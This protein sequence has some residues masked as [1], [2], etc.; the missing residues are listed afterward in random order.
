MRKMIGDK[1]LPIQD[2]ETTLDTCPQSLARTPSTAPALDV[3]TRSLRSALLADPPYQKRSPSFV[4]NPT[5]PHTLTSTNERIKVKGPLG[6][7]TVKPAAP[8][9]LQPTHHSRSNSEF[10]CSRRQSR[11]GISEGTGT[12][13]SATTR[14][15]LDQEPPSASNQAQRRAQPDAQ[16]NQQPGQHKAMQPG[17]TA[18]STATGG[19]RR[20]SVQSTRSAG[21]TPASSSSSVWEARMKMD[22]VRGGVKVFSAGAADEPADE[23]GV[24]VYRRLRRNQSEGGGAGAADTAAKKRRSWK[25]SKPVTA[26]GDLRKSRSDAA[27]AAVTTATTTATAVVARRAVARV[28]MPEKK[29]APA[30]AAAAGEVKEVVVVEVHKAAAADAKNVARGPDE[31][32][33]DDDDDHDDGGAEGEL[34]DEEQETDEEEEKEMLDL[35]DH[36]AIDDDEQTAPHQGKDP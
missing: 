27:A 23:E 34:L 1:S 24:R 21:A 22:E 5:L 6:F 28:S 19:R 17:G 15:H 36:M 14:E 35:Q 8:C 7:T 29:V 25:A 4:S 30:P 3:H 20:V 12:A 11:K 16:H 26:I 32:L 18:S 9:S 31:E 33:D 10:E 13:R 2:P